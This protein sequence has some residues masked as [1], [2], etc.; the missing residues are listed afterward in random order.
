MYVCM[1][2]YVL[3]TTNFLSRY[4]KDSCQHVCMRLFK[5]SL[6]FSIFVKSFVR[7]FPSFTRTCTVAV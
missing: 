7:C 3:L 2:V 6:T 4:N 5:N 1:Y